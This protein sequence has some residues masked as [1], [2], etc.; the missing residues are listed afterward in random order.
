MR[1]CKV[2]ALSL[3]YTRTERSVSLVRFART[4]PTDE[5]SRGAGKSSRSPDHTPGRG[6][7]SRARYSGPASVEAVATPN[8]E[9]LMASTADA[10]PVKA[11]ANPN[12]HDNITNRLDSFFHMAVNLSHDAMPRHNH[13]D[14]KNIKFAK[15]TRRPPCFW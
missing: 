9:T 11:H 2:S 1:P 13:T 15:Q 10:S 4:S 3:Q 8:A 12:A 14:L 6:A 5:R 7:P